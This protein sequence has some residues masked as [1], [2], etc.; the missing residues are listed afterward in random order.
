MTPYNT[1]VEAIRS[2]YPDT[3]AI[4]RFGSWGTPYQRADSDLDIAVLLPRETATNLEL[5][6]WA[7]LNGKV[8]Y[9]AHTDRVD[10]INLRTA[11]TTL[12]AEILRTGEPVYSADEDVRLAFE[13]LVLS[14]HQDL[15]A[16]RKGI[17]EDLLAGRWAAAL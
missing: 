13:V 2:A 10:L 12:Q 15:N 5:W 14:K 17:Q 4:Y 7:T 6:A 8:A 9:V 16:W 11:N 3:Q 1:I